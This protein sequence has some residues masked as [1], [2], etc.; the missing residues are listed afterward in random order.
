M[1][2]KID[3]EMLKKQHFWLLLIPVVIGLLLAWIGLFVGVA[4]ATEEKQK[5]N[6]AAKDEVDRAKAQSKEVLKL[7]DARKET[8]FQLRTQRWKEMWDMQQSVYEWPI[9]IGED[10]VAQVK[11]MKFGAEIS[12]DPF[13]TAFKDSYTK[14]Y[15]TLATKVAPL[16]F[17]GGGWQNVLRSAKW[18]RTPTSEDVWLAVE[19]FW[20]QREIINALASV[21]RDA[22]RLMPKT[23]EKDGL[24]QRTFAGRTWELSLRLVDKPNGVAVEGAVKNLTTRLQPFNVSNELVFDIWLNEGDSKPFRFS[25]EGVSLE[26]GKTEPVKF[27]EK[28]HTVLE[29]SPRGLFRVEQV[30]DVRTAP[31][32]RLDRLELGKLSARHT[33]VDLQM[34]SFSDKAFKEESGTA[35]ASGTSTGTMPGAPSLVGPPSSGG[36]AT[37]PGE[38][39]YNGLVRK[40]YFSRT[41]QVRAMPVGLCIIAD[42]AFLQDVQTALT[43]SKLRF[44]TVQ[45]HLARFRGSLSYTPTSSPSSGGRPGGIFGGVPGGKRGG[46]GGDDAGSSGGG[47]A[48]GPIAGAGGPLPGFPGMP[49]F[50]PFGGGGGFPGFPGSGAPRSSNEDQIAANLVEMSIYGITSLYEKFETTVKK[51]GA[52]PE[53]TEPKAADP[54]ATDPKSSEP[55]ASDPKASDPKGGEPKGTDPKSVETPK[56]PKDAAKDDSAKKDPPKSDPKGSDPMPPKK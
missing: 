9:E 56:D 30:F 24:R 10:R 48:G 42:Q 13:L 14:D 11:D 21:N 20:V 25:I 19:D 18:V 6:Q 16:Q 7:F 39:T 1:A 37:N 3:K 50:P 2:S 51:D 33:L 36:S 47:A 5:A 41:D 15:D 45:T 12:S 43:N 38:T 44:Q 32:K 4:D 52:E 40:R 26:A 46:D 54:K 23:P 31:V 35:A 28:K 34:T 49:G 27:V 29:G 8:L 55:K 22:A 53:A 17:A